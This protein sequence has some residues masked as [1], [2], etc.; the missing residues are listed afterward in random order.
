M[1]LSKRSRD[2]AMFGP[3]IVDNLWPVVQQQ[4]DG[5]KVRGVGVEWHATDTSIKSEC[6][7]EL[8]AF[9]SLSLVQLATC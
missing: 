1:V 2:G 6:W 9:L 8:S 3:L 5:E 7:P 4:E